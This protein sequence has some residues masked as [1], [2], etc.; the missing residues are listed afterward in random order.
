MFALTEYLES[1]PGVNVINGKH[2]RPRVAQAIGKQSVTLPQANGG[3]H[4]A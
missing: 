3:K 2:V 4:S 1:E